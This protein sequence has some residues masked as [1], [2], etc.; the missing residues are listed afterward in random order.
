MATI[1][2]RLDLNEAIVLRAKRAYAKRK[3]LDDNVDLEE[4]PFSDTAAAAVEY[5]GPKI[6]EH[7]ENAGLG[8]DKIDNIRPR[9]IRDELWKQL[10]DWVGDYDTKQI[11]LLRAALKLLAA[12]LDETSGTT[13]GRQRKRKN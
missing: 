13:E 10:K 2:P 4:V 1:T 8:R 6:V 9:R 7:L 5:Y 12:E 11:S 3:G